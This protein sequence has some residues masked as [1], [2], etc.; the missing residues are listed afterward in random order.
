MRTLPRALVALGLATVSVSAA[1]NGDD[2][3]HTLTNGAG[4]S[5]PG[6]L[7][8]LSHN[9]AGLIYGQAPRAT[10]AIV[11]D[12]PNF[13]TPGFGLGLIG[14][15]MGWAVGAAINTYQGTSTY[16]L[17][18]LT[19][20]PQ[21]GVAISVPKIG[22]AFGISAQG[23]GAVGLRQAISWDINAGAIFGS[24]GSVHFGVLGTGLAGVTRGLSAGLAVDLTD[25]FQLVTD[26]GYQFSG[27]GL[28]MQPG[29]LIR[30]ERV[31]LT[32]SYGIS[33]VAGTGTAISSGLSAG[34]GGK[35]TETLQAYFL[36][37][38]L[39]TYAFQFGMMF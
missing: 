38:E 29:L 37:E 39:G 20:A 34:L 5:S 6:S 16:P 2:F 33:F 4:I 8:A 23:Y 7:N 30:T 1:K 32:A 17:S 35:I 36:F 24:E 13:A 9:P 26:L 25:N 28:A 3:G 10:F 14:G 11:N 21:M 27:G 22:S 12:Q 15:T 19:L 18:P 31:V